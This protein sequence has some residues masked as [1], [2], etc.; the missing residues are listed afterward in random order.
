MST[1][2]NV[3]EQDPS[4]RAREEIGISLRA[5]RLGRVLDRLAAGCYKITLVKSE[6]GGW[7]VIIAFGDASRELDLP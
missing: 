5:V 7:S 3:P 2:P 6:A 4:A 1:F